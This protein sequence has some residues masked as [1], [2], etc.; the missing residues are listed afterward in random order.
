MDFPV[1]KTFSALLISVFLAYVVYVHQ[2]APTTKL[3]EVVLPDQQSGASTTDTSPISTPSP[4]TPAT[5]PKPAGMYTDG[6][7]RGDSVFAY[8]GDVQVGAVIQ[9]GRLSDIEIYDYP[10]DRDTSVRINSQ[11]LP[12]LISEA[13]QAQSAVIDAVSG[14][15][16][17]SPAFKQSLSS[18]LAK[19]KRN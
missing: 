19:A 11:A 18:A 1:K 9:G 7:Y 16:D 10:R 8:Y 13:I 2:F 17:T 5:P 4:S 14:A 15:S 12:I 6:T 3:P